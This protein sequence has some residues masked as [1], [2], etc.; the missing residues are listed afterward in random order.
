M[1]KKELFKNAVKNTKADKATHLAD[2]LDS[3]A[4]DKN[5]IIHPELKPLIPALLE[6]ERQLL[7]QSIRI[8]GV[9]EK[10]VLWKKTDNEYIL[11]DGHNRYEI[12]QNLK[13]QGIIVSYA[14]REQEFDSLNAVKYWM[15]INQFTRR[16]LSDKQ[17]T[18][19][20]GLRYEMEKQGYGG[21]RKSSPK[22]W[23][24]KNI[25]TSERLADEFNISKNTIEN[26]SIFARGVDKLEESFK[27]NVLKGIEKINKSD[28][29]QLAH[30]EL[31]KGI[32]NM[33][34]FQ[35][36]IHQKTT[37]KKITPL[38]KAMAES[39]QELYI[40]I[41]GIWLIKYDLVEFWAK[42]RSIKKETITE[43]FED[44]ISLKEANELQMIRFF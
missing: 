37:P 14:F 30:L 7:E 31:D 15:I 39:K 1:A 40:T 13:N 16:N 5:I 27:Q 8:E 22:F 24:L 11:V 28:I 36:I 23:D 9:R 21:N 2:F 17:R 42:K 34:E 32:Q 44:K 35:Q 3:Q 18:Y 38:K 20:I 41:T 12:V 4:R 6:E 26:A 10:I 43:N 33:D 25:R 19:L 29:Q